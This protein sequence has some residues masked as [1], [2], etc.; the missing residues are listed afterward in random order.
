VA[1]A[2]LVACDH[3]GS[4]SKDLKDTGDE[5]NYK[6]LF[7]TD[8]LCENNAVDVEKEDATDL[9]RI[10]GTR[11]INDLSSLDWIFDKR[12]SRGFRLIV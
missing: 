6:W 2:D 1:S 12:H 7:D 11:G 5:L 3:S 4:N 9:L 8:G 10:K